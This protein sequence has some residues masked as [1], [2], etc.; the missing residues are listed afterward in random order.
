M[1]KYHDCEEYD[2]LTVEWIRHRPE[3]RPEYCDLSEAAQNAM[4]DA[5]CRAM[6]IDPEAEDR[7]QAEHGARVTS[8]L[9]QCK[10]PECAKALK[11]VLEANS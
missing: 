10:H 6:R 4:T 9:K 7:W 8:H 2:A 11:V 1:G 5:E 3:Y